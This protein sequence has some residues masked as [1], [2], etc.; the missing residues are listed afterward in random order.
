M[1]DYD[2]ALMKASHANFMR[3]MHG[4]PRKVQ[5][6]AADKYGVV[7]T[8]P[9]VSTEND[10]PVEANWVQKVADMRDVTIYYRNNPSVFFFEGC[11]GDLSAQHMTDMLNVRLTWDP[12]GG[13]LTGTRAT[14]PVSDSYGIR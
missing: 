7:M 10:E 9:A 2:F 12:Y 8:V 1:V 3:P 6:E 14:G 4:A 5:V 11:N 13:R